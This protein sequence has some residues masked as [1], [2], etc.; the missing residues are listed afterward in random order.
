[1]ATQPAGLTWTDLQAR[2]E[3]GNRYELLDGELV[4]SPSPGLRHQETVAELLTELHLWARAHGG[5]ALAGPFD[6]YVH[7]REF[8]EP[9]VLYVRPERTHLFEERRIAAPPD[10]L[11]EVSSPSTRARDLGVKRDIYERFAVPE[12]WFVDLDADV[13]LVHRLDAGAYGQPEVVG[14][15]DTLQPGACPGLVIPARGLLPPR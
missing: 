4:V 6:V 3:D 11:V 12:Y 10:L 14:P 15:G 7:E 5:K 13:V 8:T 9:D 2:P 1:M